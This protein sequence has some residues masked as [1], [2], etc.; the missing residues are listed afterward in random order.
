MTTVFIVTGAASWSIIFVYIILR[1]G[2]WVEG[3][4][5]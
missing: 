5:W 4:E 3:R 2:C 1:L